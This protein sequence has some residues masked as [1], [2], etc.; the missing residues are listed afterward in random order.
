MSEAY[1]LSLTAFSFI[2][3]DYNV[4]PIFMSIY[5]PVP[6]IDMKKDKSASPSSQFPLHTAQNYST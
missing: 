1:Y 5:V 3:R 4:Y 2:S 6:R